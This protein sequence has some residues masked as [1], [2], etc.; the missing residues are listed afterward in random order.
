MHIKLNK[1]KII[2]WI[3]L[4]FAVILIPIFILKFIYPKQII[5][6]PGS[7][8]EISENITWGID[9]Q[10][11][12][13]NEYFFEGWV[14]MQGIGQGYPVSEDKS[15]WLYDNETDTFY[16]LKSQQANAR[17]NTVNSIINDGKDYQSSNFSVK[18]NLS[19]LNIKDKVFDIYICYQFMGI[20]YLQPIGTRIIYGELKN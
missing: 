10:T 16:K 5:K 12:K 6:I 20:N 13:G 17:N 4:I 15:I 9:Q 7:D 3:M 19:T 18:V 11:L 1:T 8:Y 14:L 2:M